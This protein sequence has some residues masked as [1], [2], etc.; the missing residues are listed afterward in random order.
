[1]PGTL[2]SVSCSSSHH[3]RMSQHAFIIL[4]TGEKTEA[5]RGISSEMQISIY[6]FRRL[7]GG[8]VQGRGE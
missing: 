2:P 8:I 3:F 5:Q 6:R 1:M 7:D 4:F